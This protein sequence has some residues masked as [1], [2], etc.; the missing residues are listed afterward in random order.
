[1]KFEYTPSMIS[2]IQSVPLEMQ[3]EAAALAEREY[4]KYLSIS[5]ALEEYP[6]SKAL[7]LAGQVA[8]ARVI[9]H[10]GIEEE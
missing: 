8:A 2:A 6:Q 10:F 1:M 3:L 9:E 4:F 5:W 7:H